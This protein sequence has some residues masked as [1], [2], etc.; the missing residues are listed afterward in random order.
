M[1]T[2]GADPT[3]LS[4]N[5]ANDRLPAWSPNGKQ[6]VFDS[7]R[8]RTLAQPNNAEIITMNATRVNQTRRPVDPAGDR[9]ANWQPR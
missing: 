9:D 3:N 7:D 1:S 4:N 6:I 2:S 5:P 8:H